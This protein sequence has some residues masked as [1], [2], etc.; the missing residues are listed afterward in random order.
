MEVDTSLTAARVVRTLNRIAALGGLKISFLIC[1]INIGWRLTGSWC[2]GN[3]LK[4][5]IKGEPMKGLLKGFFLALVV[6]CFAA[7]IPVNAATYIMGTV[8]R[9]EENST[10]TLVYVQRASD[11]KVI[12]LYLDD[13]T[14]NIPRALAL[15][16][17]AETNGDTVQL[18]YGGSPTKWIKIQVRYQ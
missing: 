18:Y 2:L 7:P 6:F 13:S 1:F 17:T 14:V 15:L 3:I 12:P 9:I 8:Y 11:S 10:G 16:L 4:K 5:C